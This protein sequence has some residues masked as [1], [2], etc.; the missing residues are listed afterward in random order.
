[1]GKMTRPRLTISD[2]CRPW[3]TCAPAAGCCPITTSFGTL[4]LG[5][6]STTTPFNFKL[7]VSL[8]AS[9]SVWPTSA[10]TITPATAGEKK[11]L[12]ARPNQTRTPT[13]KASAIASCQS[14]SSRPLTRR[15]RSGRTSPTCAKTLR[16]RLELRFVELNVRV[17]ALNVFVFLESVEEIQDRAHLTF[18]RF[19]RLL[20]DHPELG[21]SDLE[22]V[23]HERVTYRRQ[24]IRRRLDLRRLPVA[25]VDDSVDQGAFG[26]LV[27]A[28]AGRVDLDQTALIEHPADAPGFPQRPFMPAEDEAQFGRGPL[29][30]VG[31][32]VDDG[33]D[34]GGTVP[35]ITY[36]FDL[37]LALAASARDRAFDVVLR[38]IGGAR[39][40][41]RHLQP[42][43]RLRIRRAALRREDDLPA[44]LGEKRAALGVDFPFAQPDVVPF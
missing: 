3:R 36:L 24:C 15:L 22:P 31:R 23:F 17:D 41:N 25:D 40:L 29:P 39:F 14:R 44:Q 28:Q 13:A 35:F 38:H 8:S 7:A 43:V 37:A 10:G 18:V 2:T 1:M 20:R 9:V 6:R 4:S 30:T 32:G 42:I 16:K 34:P 12:I 21:R 27:L 5:C 26:E 11:S 19:H 33:G